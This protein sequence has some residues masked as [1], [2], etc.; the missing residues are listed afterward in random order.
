M[1]KISLKPALCAVFFFLTALV[2]SVC[3]LEPV[4][5]NEYVEDD[6][7]QGVIKR[8][9][10]KV[11]VVGSDPGV[12]AGNSRITGLDPQKYY[13]IEEWGENEA[14]W[15]KD[16]TPLS[17]QFVKK[18]GSRNGNLT[19]I[20]MVS[21]RTIT[22]LTNNRYYR[23]RAAKPLKSTDISSITPA[24]VPTPTP[25][26]G[27]ITLPDGNTYNLTLNSAFNGYSYVKIP[28]TPASPAAT[29]TVSGNITLESAGTVTDYV[30]A[31][32][33]TDGNINPDNFYVLRVTI[34]ESGESQVEIDVT[35]LNPMGGTSIVLY[36]N[37]DNA[38][39][40]EGDTI[41][42]N[43]GGS[44][45]LV[46]QNNTAFSTITWTYNG[47]TFTSNTL[48]FGIPPSDDIDTSVA[49]TYLI[50]INATTNGDNAPQ[51]SWFR[52]VVAGP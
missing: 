29:G 24:P 27:E 7:V 52:V 47:T 9:A 4:T 3:I 22:G 44:L 31:D 25:I 14:G 17:V 51:S 28:I 49:G 45:N 1:R 21:G 5:V 39:V 43:T 34:K 2:L 19:Y 11:K 6:K 12:T 38:G 48:K 13:M 46:V 20:G 10:E 41:T 15:D 30:F 8:G 32:I 36:N 16:E 35:T 33:D 23:V 26:N 50:Y 37:T 40:A 42:I 18:D